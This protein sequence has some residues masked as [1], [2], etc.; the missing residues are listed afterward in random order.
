MNEYNDLMDAMLKFRLDLAREAEQHGNLPRYR[1]EQLGIRFTGLVKLLERVQGTIPGA[2]GATP[3]AWEKTQPGQPGA[4]LWPS[5]ASP[6]PQKPAGYE[7]EG[8]LHEAGGGRM[9]CLT[10]GVDLPVDFAPHD[11]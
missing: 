6:L 10:C 11:A 2:E 8:H 1:L 5:K 9:M 3:K 7:H 4:A